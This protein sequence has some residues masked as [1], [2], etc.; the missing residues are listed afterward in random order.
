MEF[1]AEDSPVPTDAPPSEEE[2]G[3]ATGEPPRLA[4][5]IQGLLAPVRVAVSSASDEER[6][7][8]R[9]QPPEAPAEQVRQVRGR[10]ESPPTMGGREAYWPESGSQRL[11]L[12]WLFLA[13]GL[14]ILLPSLLA[15]PW[16]KGVPAQ[17]PGVSEAFSAIEGLPVQAN[18]V[19]YWAYD[20][21]T[22]GELDLA[23]LPVIE[24]L[25][26]RR[27]RMSIVTLLPGG[28][29]TARRL[30]ERSR[31]EWQR[32]ESLIAVA[33]ST[34]VVPIQY[35][36]G[37]PATLALV[38]QNPAQIFGDRAPTLSDLAVVFGAQA[39][40]VQHWLEQA[41]PINQTPVIAV[42]SAAADPVLRPYWDSGQ[43]SGLVSG[44]DGASSYQSLLTERFPRLPRSL[45][46][47]RQVVLQDWGVIIFL[48]AIV[49]GNLAAMFS[50][51]PER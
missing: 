15:L 35:L 37:G 40:D 2:S 7:P 46:L 17:W 51:G 49:L 41:A 3:G 19:V 14:A 44:Y 12:P 4:M 28:P 8:A 13:L 29:A 32:S 39:E 23:A 30:I 48:L 11:R 16:P 26:Q 24:H 42:V 1:G 6:P 50:R 22:A 10:M 27:A 38:A 18:V 21:S 47:D 9:A 31:L 20:P 34:W 33:E 36:S 25:L 5:G 43:L 45:A